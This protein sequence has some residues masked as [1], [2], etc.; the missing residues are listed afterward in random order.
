MIGHH[1]K[2]LY[3]CTLTTIHVTGKEIHEVF[4]QT[5]KEAEI[6]GKSKKTNKDIL[7]NPSK[8]PIQKINQIQKEECD[9]NN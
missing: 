8:E 3:Y 4:T 5:M 6:E 7:K 9:V 2:R 1:H